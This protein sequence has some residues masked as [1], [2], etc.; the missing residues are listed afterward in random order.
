[1]IVDCA[2]YESGVRMQG[3]LQLENALEASRTNPDS[4]VW[5]GLAEPDAAEFD[6]VA[7]EFDLHPLAVE[8][9]IHAHQR[10]KLEMYG[11]TMFVVLKAAAYVGHEDAI[12]LSEVM[13][14]LGDRFLV[15]VRHG[16]SSVLSD[17][18]SR[19]ESDPERLKAGGV[20]VLHAVLDQVV[21][22]YAMV[23]SRFDE[24]VDEVER[25]VFSTGR[26]NHAERLYKLK[27]EVLEFRQAVI[28]LID[29]LEDLASG[30]LTTA[31]MS[32]LEYFRDVHDHVQRVADRIEAVDN[33]LAS[34]LNANLAQVGVRQNEDMRKISAWV[35]IIALPTM[36]AGIYGMNFDHMPE[37]G[38]SL[39]YPFAVS[40][41]VLTSASLF[42][43]FRR[44]DWL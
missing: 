28:P 2:V 33:L 34:A 37:L 18:R 44:R 31:D 23:L 10:P 5:V 13:L 1:M 25:A 19:L 8:D 16:P 30:Q 7:A 24:D 22:N 27:R 14:F 17:V 26:D 9:A 41:M 3:E 4:F 38:W 29:P 6:S 32:L 36:I 20:G 21:D 35:A 15:S 11:R 40:L 42:V 39:G 12:E 43:M